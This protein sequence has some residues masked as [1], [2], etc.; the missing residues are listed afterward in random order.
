MVGRFE[1][2]LAKGGVKW[3][4]DSYRSVST[5][6]KG[7]QI[8]DLQRLPSPGRGGGYSSEFLAGVCGSVLQTLILFQA[9]N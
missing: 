8:S 5:K 1:P 3:V 7:L 4:D 6:W 2:L 9:K